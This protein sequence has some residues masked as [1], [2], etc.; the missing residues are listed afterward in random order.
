MA[1][2]A[3]WVFS[4]VR[5]RWLGK[6]PHPPRKETSTAKVS[7][8]LCWADD[9]IC[10]FFFPL[11]SFLSN[12]LAL[13]SLFLLNPIR[14]RINA[15]EVTFSLGLAQLPDARAFKKVILF[16]FLYLP[17]THVQSVRELLQSSTRP[18]RV[19]PRRSQT[20]STDSVP[21][22]TRQSHPFV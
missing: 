12:A 16:F 21:I 20:G 9:W 11:A 6:R 15:I 7:G 18:Q 13:T 2:L 8:H 5:E 10:L 14:A 17:H 22:G 1:S 3:I 19:K 4:F